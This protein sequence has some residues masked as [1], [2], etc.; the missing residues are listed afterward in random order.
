M[1]SRRGTLLSMTVGFSSNV[2]NFTAHAAVAPFLVANRFQRRSLVTSTLSLAV[3]PTDVVTIGS[4]DSI[5]RL[6]KSWTTPISSKVAY[7]ATN[8]TSCLEAPRHKSHK[9]KVSNYTPRCW[10]G[11]DAARA[12]GRR[13]KTML[14][15]LRK[16]L[17]APDLIVVLTVNPHFE[18]GK[19]LD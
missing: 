6:H 17:D 16:E 2:E 1:P 13:L 15:Q 14:R 5:G 10:H 8:L 4:S 18:R 11:L 19:N 9:Q 7:N 3:N 12:Y